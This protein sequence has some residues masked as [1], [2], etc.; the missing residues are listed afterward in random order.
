MR[1]YALWCSTVAC[2]AICAVVI[3]FATLDDSNGAAAAVQMPTACD[4]LVDAA[5]LIARGGSAAGLPSGTD[6]IFPDG[7]TPRPDALQQLV[8]ACDA[9]RAGADAA[10]P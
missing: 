4:N 10:A 5:K 9:A 7:G 3:L 1:R 6:S 8:A 2:V